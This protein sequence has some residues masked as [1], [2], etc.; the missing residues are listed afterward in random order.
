MVLLLLKA[1]TGEE[2][3]AAFA[4]IT[5]KRAG[6]LLVPGDVFFTSRRAQIIALAK[7]HA[8]PA[9]YSFRENTAAGGLM[10]YPRYSGNLFVGRPD[11]KFQT[12][13]LPDRLIVISVD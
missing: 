7:R 4:T 10:S 3:D 8:V 13:P 12:D 1:T 11:A 9:I 6:G 2:I 5:G